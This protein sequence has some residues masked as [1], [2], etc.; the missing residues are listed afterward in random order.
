MSQHMDAKAAIDHLMGRKQLD[1]PPL[2]EYIVDEAIMRPVLAQMGRTWVDSNADLTGWL[3]NFSAF[4][5][6]MGYSLVKFELALPFA[7]HHLLA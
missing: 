4:Y 6:G 1:R 3:D 7:S 5:Q 2:V